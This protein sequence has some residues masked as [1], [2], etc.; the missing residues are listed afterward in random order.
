VF[1]GLAGSE[2]LF[3]VACLVVLLSVVLHG[4]GIAV[5]LRA[6]GRQARAGADGAAVAGGGGQRGAGSSQPS[7]APLVSSRTSEASVGI[8]R[9]LPVQP[10]VPDR[11]TIG[12]VDELRARGDEVIVVDARADRSYRADGITAQGA[13][14]L[15]PNDAVRSAQASRLSQHGTLVIYCA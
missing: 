14:R 1:A 13:V 8:Q 12:E 10:E 15:D 3:T 2:R 6:A 5:F 7:S 9:A 4:T 11:I